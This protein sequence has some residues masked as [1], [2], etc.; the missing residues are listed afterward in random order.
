MGA[1]ATTRIMATKTAGDR[2]ADRHVSNGMAFSKWIEQPPY[3]ER[4]KEREKDT[5]TGA[6]HPDI[7]ADGEKEKDRGGKKAGAREKERERG[8]VTAV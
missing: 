7:D 2:E 1:V 8:R 6:D 3:K 4:E 5:E